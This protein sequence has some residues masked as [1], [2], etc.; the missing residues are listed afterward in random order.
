[1]ADVGKE[2][3]RAA[4]LAARGKFKRALA[5]YQREND[6][7]GAGE[8]YAKLGQME[9][10]A[11]SFRKAGEYKRSAQIMASMNRHEEA[12]RLYSDAGDHAQAAESLVLAQKFGEAAK[13]YERV[14]NMARA[15]ELYERAGRLEKAAQLYAENGDQE[16][17]IRLLQGN[18]RGDLA[19]KICLAAG[20]YVKAAQLF[21]EE[22]R[23]LDAAD[24]FI[25][26][27]MKPEAVDAYEAA[28]SLEEASALSEELGMLERAGKIQEQ[29]GNRFRAA[30]LYS[31]GGKYVAA[32]RIFEQDAYMFEAAQMYEKDERTADRA[33]V[34][35]KATYQSEI[36]WQAEMRLPVWD[37][38]LAEKAHRVLV[39]L[40]G[41]EV[42]LLSNE[43]EEN[44]RFRVPM[45]AR[46]RSVAITPTASHIAIGTE[47]RSVYLLDG[48]KNLQW[49][50]ELGA[51][52]R[53]LVFAEASDQVVAGCTDGFIM[54]LTMEG[55]DQWQFQADYKIW[56]I[57]KHE[58]KELLLAGCGNGNIY[59]L[60]F[61]GDLVW[62]RNTGDWV[63]KVAIHEDGDLA[64]AVLG[65][66]KVCLIDL[67]DRQIRWTYTANET[68]Q[69]V[70]FWRENQFIVTTNSGAFIL[71]SD[72]TRIWRH[73]ANDRITRVVRAKDGQTVL[74]GQFDHGVLT[75]GLLGC[76]LR[77]AMNFEKCGEFSKAADIYVD[78]NELA[79]AAPLY[80]RATE[81]E[82][83]GN[84]AKRIGDFEAAGEYYEKGGVYAEAAICFE[85]LNMV[86]RAAKCYEAAG[87]T[88]K[89]GALLAGLGDQVKAAELHVQSG[90]FNAAGVLFAKAGA[91][92]EALKALEKAL[93]S[94]TI[95]A[96]GGVALGRIY[97]LRD[98]LDDVIKLLQ[99]YTRDEDHGKAAEELLGD[100]FMKKELFSLAIDHYKE[101]L[102]D[103]TDATVENLDIQYGLGCAYEQ[104]GMYDEAKTVFQDILVVDYYYRDV[105]GRL[106]HIREMS[107]IF[108]PVATRMHAG[109]GSSAQATMPNMAPSRYEIVRKLGEGGM[110]IVYLAKDTKLSRDVALKVLPSKLSQNDE[111]RM[112]FVREARAVAAL[113]HKNIVGV[114]DIGEEWGESFIA[115]EFI[116]GKSLRDVL[117]A[118]KKLSAAEVTEYAKQ[119]AAGLG[120]AHSRGVVHRDIKPENIMITGSAHDVKIMDFGLARMDDTSNLTQEGAIMGTLRYMSPEQIK[121][122]RVDTATDI[123]A[124]GIMLFEML[125]G[126]PPFPEGNLGYHH[127]NTMPKAV[128]EVEP[129][130][131]I[132]LS[133]VI[134]KCLAKSAADR[135]ADGKELYRALDAFTV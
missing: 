6:H 9:E 67:A 26:A 112:R 15:A 47:E 64:V 75:M 92:D 31:E 27:N 40:A 126:E 23:H 21:T 124:V 121:G 20:D 132:E 62:K 17:A 29:L 3:G 11:A 12:S 51:E 37:L 105:T 133:N 4:A 71:H 123:Y 81:Y 125:A 58:G 30:Q 63:A 86:D 134:N 32:G 95:T 22:G 42:V 107:G 110:G 35:F 74:F 109:G 100:T 44:W 46:A 18:D 117:N 127:V 72:Q 7:C 66:N 135:F 108:S 131:P 68:V 90:D 55:T 76:E 82:K 2:V 79:R 128:H 118:E 115:M 10:A 87:D 48:Q 5:E 106:D 53:G 119:I 129:D 70:E 101:A 43:G 85:E 14:G 94:E 13:L 96:E 19:A 50:R 45:G 111:L 114:Y 57:E 56:C 103:V 122:Q 36:A 28:G 24:A 25:R 83:A 65:L 60:T 130:V 38:A 54:A 33:A 77:A 97:L 8:M 61:G 80:A 69:D 78:E 52:V 120:E 41:P 84:I 102:G 59:L 99:S 89:A 116:E 1:M 39:G 73:S 104:A 16:S 34:L 49:K 88:S 91:H 93:E 113:S 98:R